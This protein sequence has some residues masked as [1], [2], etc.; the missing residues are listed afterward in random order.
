[1]I[2]GQFQYQACDERQ[3]F[4]PEAVTLKWTVKV[5]PFDRTRVAPNLQHKGGR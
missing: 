4:P 1:M 5:S 2:D 3:C